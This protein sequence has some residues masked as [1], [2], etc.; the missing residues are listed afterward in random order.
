MLMTHNLGAFHGA[1][2]DSFRADG[3]TSQVTVVIAGAKVSADLTG[4][5]VKIDLAD[6]PTAF[7]NNIQNAGG[8]IRAYTTAGAEL[9]IDIPYID[10]V[11]KVGWLFVRKD[12]PYAGT[13]FILRTVAHATMYADNAT[14]GM[15]AVWSGM[16][17]VYSG[18]SLKNRASATGALFTPITG[19]TADLTTR[20]GYLTMSNA[21]NASPVAT[22]GV[23]GP[24]YN[25][26]MSCTARRNSATAPTANDQVALAVSNGNWGDANV[27]KYFNAFGR[28]HGT[29]E[30][31][32]NWYNINGTGNGLTGNGF[33]I[34]D[35]D[36]RIAFTA[37]G[38]DHR[39]YRDG[40]QIV[41]G[42]KASIFDANMTNGYFNIG[43]HASILDPVTSYW[44]GSIGDAYLMPGAQSQPRLLAEFNN[45]DW[46]RAGKGFYAIS[47]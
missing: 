39:I 32:F 4:F 30:A 22:K 12:V 2:A 19:K 27:D 23:N 6:L 47:S 37:N 33:N 31:L 41:S 15:A 7:W 5:Q 44:Y 13:S 17:A 18:N 16:T 40:Q 10:T 8:N 25:W 34:N 28:A 26:T 45:W 29:T 3:A 11:N 35:V 1:V 9:P 46:V 24:N 38:I 14:Y 42:S 20:P 43:C 36:L 21:S